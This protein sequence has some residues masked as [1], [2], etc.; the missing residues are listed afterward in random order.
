M[1]EIKSLFVD[2]LK[3]KVNKIFCSFDVRETQ[4]HVRLHLS[5]VERTH[6]CNLKPQMQVMP[7]PS[8]GTK[9]K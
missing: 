9:H 7:V 8:F 6:K 1:P 4:T 2:K 5:E 3:H